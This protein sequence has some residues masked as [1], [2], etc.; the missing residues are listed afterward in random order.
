MGFEWPWIV[1][2]ELLMWYDG[3]ALTFLGFPFSLH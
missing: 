3:L 2:C 1:V